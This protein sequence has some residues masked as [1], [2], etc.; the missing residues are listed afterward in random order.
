M[1]K[2]TMQKIY[3]DIQ[4]V[5][6]ILEEKFGRGVKIQIDYNVKF[7]DGSAMPDVS[8]KEIVITKQN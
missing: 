2:E 5:R 4:D 3:L 1:K 7:N 8:F 6:E